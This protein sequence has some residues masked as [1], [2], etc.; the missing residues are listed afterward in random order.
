M[1]D[2]VQVPRELPPRVDCPRIFGKPFSTRIALH[3][4][5]S[6]LE[7]NASRRAGME[8]T[9]LP[10]LGVFRSVRHALIFSMAATA[11]TCAFIVCI[12]YAIRALWRR[13]FSVL[14]NIPG[15]PRKS[16]VTGNL[17]QF[18]DLDGWA[19]QKELEENYGQ[20]VKLHG[21][22]G[23]R[24][25]YI[26]DP[27]ALQ[28]ILV[29]DQDI[30]EELPE[31]MSMA[32]LI[33]GKGI[34]STI[35][36]DHRK[37]RKIMVPAF[38]TANLRGMVP[39]FYEVAE[40]ARDGLISPDVRDGPK[41]LD[42]GAILSRISLEMIGRTGIGYSFDQLLP[43]DEQG[44]H[45]AKTLKEIPFLGSKLVALLPLLPLVL[46]IP[47]PAFRRAMIN[48]VPVRALHL[49]RDLIDSMHGSATQLV[50]ERK[51]AIK[52][53]ELSVK[54]DA[55]DI[56][57]LLMKSNMSAESGMHLTDDELVA[58][59]SMIILA[60]TDS[61]SSALNR[62][63]HTLTVYPAV[64]EKLRAELLATPEHLDHDALVALPYLDAF[65]R[66]MLRVFPPV[67]PGIFRYAC[68]DTVLPLSRPLV[69]V[70]GKLMDSIPVP[71]GT[72]TYVAISAANHNRQI[73]GED[74]LEFRP[75]RWIGGNA[76][77]VTT[78]M[79][80]VYA[81]TLTFLGG[82]RSCI[83][84]KFSQLEMK[85]V[86]C[87]LLRAFKFSS[88]DPRIKWNMTGN[89]VVPTVDGQSRLPIR[90]ERLNG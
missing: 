32:G 88:P 51:A 42:L 77:S 27:A 7:D 37:Y 1:G 44:D 62:M 65:I 58:A 59:T 41:M 2:A 28:S 55:K 40:R 63:L 35:G 86:L 48:F 21:F 20:V 90:V 29:K 87:V 25:L 12:V 49:I 69:G 54:E 30:Y 43:G 60:A 6:P 5:L 47:F 52:S 8:G 11:V 15:P 46:K 64:Q 9:Q 84:F 33:F 89:T 78:K 71:R 17:T 67:M 4:E 36:A 19:F 56:M 39:M 66:E 13:A 76:E 75:E 10:R 45:Y 81:N 61:T 82:G 26:F 34:L 85:A 80:G 31:I 22:L 50:T 24:Q 72:I 57:S 18:H 68:K 16:F 3:A 53:G 73:W 23:A 74:A 83:G 70:D 14:D 79:C 38:S